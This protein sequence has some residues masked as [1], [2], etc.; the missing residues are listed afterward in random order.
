[1]ID[2]FYDS[3]TAEIKQIAVNN[4]IKTICTKKKFIE[5]ITYHDTKT[6]KKEELKIINE[7]FKAMIRNMLIQVKKK[8]DNFVTVLF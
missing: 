2:D 6:L 5:T 1:M 7:I 3:F 8:L 4:R